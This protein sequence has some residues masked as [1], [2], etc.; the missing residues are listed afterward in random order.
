MEELRGKPTK[1]ND[2]NQV[3]DVIPEDRRL[4]VR[5]GGDMLG[6]GKT[7]VQRILSDLSMTRVLCAMG[8]SSTT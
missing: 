6:I 4:T 8:S 2:N 7:S 1:R 5:E 3:M